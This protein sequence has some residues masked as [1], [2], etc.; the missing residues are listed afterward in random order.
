MAAHLR[1]NSRVIQRGVV[2]RECM[3][4]G[5]LST[6]LWFL[7][8]DDLIARLSVRGV[9]IHVYADDICLIAVGTFPN[10]VSGLMK[11]ALLTVET[12]C[13][14]VG[15]SVNTDN[16]ELLHTAFRTEDRLRKE[17]N[18]FTM[19]FCRTTF[20]EGRELCCA[21]SRD[22]VVTYSISLL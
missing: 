17:T 1:R 9:Y 22:S 18:L 16:T 8:V 21:C 2:S 15:V 14:E 5:E 13:N 11:W 19:A 7:V 12:W 6:I 4:G 10:P 20:E 3:Q